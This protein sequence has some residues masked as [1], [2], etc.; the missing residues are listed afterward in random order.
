MIRKK[1]I[2]GYFDVIFFLKKNWFY[3]LFKKMNDKY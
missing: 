2:S 1:I 3:N